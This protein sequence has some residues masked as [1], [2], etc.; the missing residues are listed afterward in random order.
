MLRVVNSC[1]AGDPQAE[2]M[3]TTMS[4]VYTIPNSTRALP[5]S[6]SAQVGRGVALLVVGIVLPA[7]VHL[8]PSSMPLGPILMPLLIPVALAAFLL[9]LRSALLVSAAMPFLSLATS[10]M[11]PVPIALELVVEGAV[12]VATVQAMTRTR[13]RWWAAYAVGAMAS[14]SVGVLV[15]VVAMNGNLPT[16]AMEMARGLVGL[17]LA[18]L[19]L[20]ALFRLF[21]SRKPLD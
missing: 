12:L 8:I 15:L 20:P 6:L 5:T 9:P 19:V 18:G 21:D 7:A 10:G 14:R 2:D 4:Q 17:S 3:T 16:V 11:P 1:Y 13:V